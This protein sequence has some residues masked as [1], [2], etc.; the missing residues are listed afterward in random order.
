MALVWFYRDLTAV[1]EGVGEEWFEKVFN[2]A[3][4]QDQNQNKGHK[5]QKH[6]YGHRYAVF[7]AVK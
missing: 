4:G 5:W 1:M 2:R 3:G 7:K 6:N